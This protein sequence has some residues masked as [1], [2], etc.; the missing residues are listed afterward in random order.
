MRSHALATLAEAQAR[1]IPATTEQIIEQ[2]TP[3]LSQVAPSGMTEYDRGEWLSAAGLTLSELSAP[4]DL[5]ASGCRAARHSTTVD[6]PAKI[7]A[8]IIGS[9]SEMLQLRKVGLCN[10]R[11]AVRAFDV[12]APVIDDEPLD[13]GEVNEMNV[14]MR[15][16]RV[17][18]RYRADGQAFQL[19]DGDVDPCDEMRAAA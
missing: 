6:H 14:L 11:D 17:A 8:S 7:V 9:T 3:C 13:P 10:A 1:L 19:K 15:K 18:T 4:F 12:P 2:L 5:I 16:M